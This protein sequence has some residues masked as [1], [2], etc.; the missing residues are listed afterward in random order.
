MNRGHVGKNVWE[1]YLKDDGWHLSTWRRDW[2]KQIMTKVA[3][4]VC[5]YIRL[6]V[7]FLVTFQNELLIAFM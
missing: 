2:E 6:F 1:F 5:S 3:S 4:S 7:C